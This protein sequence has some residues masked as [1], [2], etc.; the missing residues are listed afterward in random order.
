MVLKELAVGRDNNLNLIRFL[1]ASLVIFSHSYWL[2]GHLQD[3]PLQ[4][5]CGMETFGS[6]GV[7][8]FFSISGFLITKSLVRQPL[9][10]S[11]VRARVLRIF[12]GLIA[13]ALFC[14][15]VV[16]PIATSLP[17]ISYIKQPAV[18]DFLWRHGTLHDLP[19]KLPGVFEYNPIPYNVN[20]PIWTLPA[21]LLL[22]FMVFLLGAIILII[23]RKQNVLSFLLI[24]SLLLGYFYGIPYS[25]SYLLEISWWLIS[26]A[27]GSICYLLRRYIRL[28]I[29]VF[30]LM[31]V[32]FLVMFHF[33]FRYIKVAFDIVLLYGLLLFAYL[34]EFQIRR[35][36]K[37]GDFSYGLYIY[38]LP[39]QQ[40]M[41]QKTQMTSPILNFIS[42]Y[43]IALPVAVASWYFL[44]KPLLR[45]K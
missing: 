7:D 3:E 31:F 4:K 11:F 44:E 21:E 9:L 28:N 8:I 34:P 12:P 2:T 22:Y 23:Q 20:S 32:A 26:F 15:F 37:T 19:N 40:L 16:G 5:L 29:V 36:Y 45:W 27:G 14:T 35:F 33:R 1:A 18:Y 39:I 13:S 17:L 42:S 43:L 10:G 38:A 6:L 25:A 24:L 41:V 30:L